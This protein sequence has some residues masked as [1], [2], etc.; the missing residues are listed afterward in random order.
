MKTSVKV[1]LSVALIWIILTLVVFLAGY[2]APFFVFGILLNIFMLLV[3]IS[4][5][6][7]FT[8]KE[9]G[10][11]ETLFLDDFKTAMQSGIVYTLIISGFVYLYHEVI[12][13]SIKDRLV[14]ARLETI[15]EMV[16]DEA[17]YLKLQEN[18]PQ[19]QEK[20]YDDYIE[21]QELSIKGIISSFSVFIFHMMGLF[22]FSMFFSL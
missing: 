12:D 5:G 3:A 8:R 2:A 14:E 16:P 11:E 7:F 17:T 21:N 1:A 10:F 9:K 13:S 20:S 4:L 22:I 15:Q 6:L 19:W 18:D